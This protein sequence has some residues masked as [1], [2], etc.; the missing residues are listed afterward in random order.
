MH[1]TYFPDHTSCFLSSMP[2]LWQCI[3]LLCSHRVSI[4]SRVFSFFP[5]FLPPMF[6]P[7]FLPSIIHF[8]YSLLPPTSPTFFF[9]PFLSFPPSFLSSLLFFFLPPFTLHY[10]VSL[11]FLSFMLSFSLGATPS[12]APGPCQ[13]WWSGDHVVLGTE[14]VSHMQSMH[15]NHLSLPCPPGI[16][17]F[18]LKILTSLKTLQF[19]Y[20]RRNEHFVLWISP[21]RFSFL[22][23]LFS[24]SLPDCNM[25][26]WSTRSC[27]PVW[28]KAVR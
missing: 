13:T 3:Q 19:L 15:S 28:L 17:K 22:L 2:L 5:S 16:I 1:W 18:Q 25:Q 8:F 27:L 20:S 14:H 26:K 10:S 7:P 24:S 11:P 9:P 23:W 4:K 12:G 6:L 21:D